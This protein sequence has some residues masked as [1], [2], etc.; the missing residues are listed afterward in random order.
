MATAKINTSRFLAK[1]NTNQT[2]RVGSVEAS[3]VDQG[4]PKGGFLASGGN[5][6]TGT[7]GGRMAGLAGSAKAR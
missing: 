1:G 7:V 6:N 3:P 4:S 5:K 2:A